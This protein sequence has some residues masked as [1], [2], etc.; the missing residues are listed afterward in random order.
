MSSDLYASLSGARAAW[1]DLDRL[2]NNVANASTTGFKGDRIRFETIGPTESPLG[3][4][5]AV[6]EG[7]TPDSRDGTVVSDGVSTHLALQGNGWF[8]LGNDGPPLLTRDGRFSLNADG[9]LVGVGGRPVLGRNGPI[10]VPVGESIRITE[11]GKIF[12]STSGEMDQLVIVDAPV[13]ALTDNQYT[14]A[15]PVKSGDARVVQGALEAS[16]SD[17]MSA[18][19]DLIQASRYVEALQKVMQASDE[20]SARLNRIGGK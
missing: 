17:P 3:Q 20:L 7:A 2:G 4:A 10:Q 15:G 5:Y 19:I 18:M 12:G 1:Q 14:P 16:N 8:S 13:K 9:L 6:S 11:D